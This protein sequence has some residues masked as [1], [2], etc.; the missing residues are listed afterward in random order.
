M[1]TLLLPPSSSPPTLFLP[2]LK[3]VAR[4]WH[5]LAPFLA[6]S[7]G[8]FGIIGAAIT[9]FLN[10]SLLA[11]FIAAPIIEEALKPSGLYLMLAKWPRVLR[12][13]LYTVFLAA[14]AGL[15]FG[16]I[17]SLVY[18]NFYIDDPSTQTIIWR[19]TVCPAMHVVCCVIFSL[20]INR[21][22]IASVR[23]ETKFLSSGKR[24]IFSA[25]ALHSL[26]NITVTVLELGFHW[27]K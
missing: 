20:A 3:P 14:L 16:L 15:A 22:L 23:G 25:M 27:F 7:G 1:S 12:N 26:Y 9:E 10:S 24:F 17:E 19:F 11:A 18:I 5:F 6:L 21:N 13:P 4:K 2:L 8:I